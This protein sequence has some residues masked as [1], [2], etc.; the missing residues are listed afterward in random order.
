METDVAKQMILMR[1][2]DK[3]AVQ[4]IKSC[5]AGSDAKRRKKGALHWG[6]GRREKKIE[7]G[8]PFL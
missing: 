6:N 1:N 7:G 8:D 3:N 4:D 5:R 2:R